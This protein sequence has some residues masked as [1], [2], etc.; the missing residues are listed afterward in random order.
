[1]KI[2]I[3]L[4]LILFILG[5][6]FFTYK[7][8]FP[9]RKSHESLLKRALKKEHFKEEYFNNLIKEDL[10]VKSSYG[11]DLKGLLY[12]QNTDKFIILIHGITC[13]YETMKKYCKMYIDMGY[14]IALYDQRNHGYSG[15]KFTTYGLYEKYDVKSIAD[16]IMERFQPKTL[17]VHGESLGAGTAMLYAS[18]DDRLSFCVEDCGYTDAFEALKYR[19][20]ND[21]TKVVGAFTWLNVWIIKRLYNFNI[22]DAS[23]IKYINNIKCPILFVHGT[24]DDYVPLYMV[25]TLYE[26]FN[27]TKKIYLAENAGHVQ[28]YPSNKEKYFEELKAFLETI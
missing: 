22:Y 6:I 20:K 14:S 17:G 15:G 3:F 16:Y 27:G 24:K 9:R 11:Y 21:Y 12:L 26:T 4:I 19:A 28:S 8:L 13:N 18:I 25:H 5:T 10:K 1:M 23:P 2:V 7:M